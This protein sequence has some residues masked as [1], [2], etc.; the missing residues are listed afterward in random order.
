MM[1]SRQRAELIG[2]WAVAWLAQED[3]L[4]QVF[5]GSTGA[6]EADI[7][8]SVQNVE[9]QAA[10]LDFLLMDDAWITAFC[11]AHELEADTALMARAAL[12]GG[13]QMHW[14]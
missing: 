11:Q 8:A 14:T 3:E 4:F 10:V 12:P 13:Q 6:N 5:M 2:L 7:R 9:F 1:M